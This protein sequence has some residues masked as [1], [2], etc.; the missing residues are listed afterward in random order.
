MEGKP[1]PSAVERHAKD[2]MHPAAEA[3]RRRYP[4]FLLKAVDWAMEVDP[5]LR[6]QTAEALLDALNDGTEQTASG[7]NTPADPARNGSREHNK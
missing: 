1:P 7:L 5:T 2:E 3:F 6:P 4:G